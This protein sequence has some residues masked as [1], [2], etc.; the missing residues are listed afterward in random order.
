VPD[1][2]SRAYGRLVP[3]KGDGVNAFAE[4]ERANAVIFFE[5]ETPMELE[6]QVNDLH[7]TCPINGKEDSFAVTVRY[8][9]ASRL[10]ELGWLR[11][12]L[13]GCANVT[14]THEAITADIFETL[15]SLIG[16]SYIQLTT[17]WNPV[18]GVWC[19]IRMVA[20]E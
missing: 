3:A 13:D 1:L 2:P 16:P 15:V 8:V 14:A 19:T 18:E 20:G 6:L 17:V 9:P 4:Q 12:Y 11:E 5:S 10:I 7:C